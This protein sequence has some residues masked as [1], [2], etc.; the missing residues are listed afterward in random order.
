M[1]AQ[2]HA[3]RR[4]FFF[5]LC[6]GTYSDKCTYDTLTYMIDLSKDSWPINQ[7]YIAEHKTLAILTRSVMHAQFHAWR[8]FFFFVSR[9]LLWQMYLRHTYL[10]DRFIGRL[11]AYKSSIYR[12]TQNTYDPVWNWWIRS[13]FNRTP[14]AS[15]IQSGASNELHACLVGVKYAGDFTLRYEWRPAN[16]YT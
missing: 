12:R 11:V 3:W 10:H 14:W 16:I 1:H 5:S 2:F 15:N 13:H 8:R 9:D 6:R 4:F 7:L